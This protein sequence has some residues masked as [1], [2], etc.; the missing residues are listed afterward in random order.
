MIDKISNKGD[1]L[2]RHMTGNYKILPVITCDDIVYHMILTGKRKTTVE[3]L[4]KAFNNRELLVNSALSELIESSIIAK[5]ETGEITLDTGKILK[6]RG[7][8]VIL[9][10]P[11]SIIQSTIATD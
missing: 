6:K 3:Q 2:V 9:V 7:N 10:Y 8:D 11:S 1:I 5:S 4:V